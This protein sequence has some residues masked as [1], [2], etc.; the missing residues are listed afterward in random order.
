MQ[1]YIS[2]VLAEAGVEGFY[3][4]IVPRQVSAPLEVTWRGQK[5]KSLHHPPS[6]LDR[7]SNDGRA[8]NY[9]HLKQ[10][11]MELL[12]RL[13]GNNV[14]LN[15]GVFSSLERYV[16]ALANTLAE[17][18]VYR[19]GH[20]GIGL[21]ALS[22]AT[23]EIM[24]EAIGARMSALVASHTL[25]IQQESRWRDYITNAGLHETSSDADRDVACDAEE[26][27]TVLER[28]TVQEII[29]PEI[30]A[31]L[32]EQRTLVEETAE[33]LSIQ[34]RGYWTSFD[35]TMIG[36]AQR[37]VDFTRTNEF[38]AW[39]EEKGADLIARFGDQTIN[40]LV[41]YGSHAAALIILLVLFTPLRRLSEKIPTLGWLETVLDEIKK[42][43]LGDK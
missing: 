12:E 33:P 15:S 16:D 31:S 40:H 5:L 38:D 20:V 30:P 29:D 23:A 6:A 4:P 13:S 2:T 11:A 17:I 35:N 22:I 32:R 10:E 34:L 39:A 28:E 9:D 21:E 26:I 25:F 1:K 36:L 8:S 14:A 27:T 7:A 43:T 41:D 18:E 24:D 37:A 3:S 42:K 19:L